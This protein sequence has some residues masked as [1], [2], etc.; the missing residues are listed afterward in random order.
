MLL[1]RSG[2]LSS[3]EGFPGAAML[4]QNFGKDLEG[5]E[6]KSSLLDSHT[7]RLCLVFHV[8]PVARLLLMELSHARVCL[9]CS[10]SLASVSIEF[11]KDADKESGAWAPRGDWLDKGQATIVTTQFQAED[12]KEFLT[13]SW[14]EF[15]FDQMTEIV[16]THDD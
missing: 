7:D 14:P 1:F 10:F 4:M 12:Y 2:E 13:G 8:Q 3:E 9:A 15:P 11:V 6:S 5:H 16:V